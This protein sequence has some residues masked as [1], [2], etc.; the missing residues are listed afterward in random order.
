MPRTAMHFGGPLMATP[1]AKAHRTTSVVQ[2]L[3]ASMSKTKCA[4]AMVASEC[5]FAMVASE[6][7]FAVV[8]SECAFAMVA[9]ECAQAIA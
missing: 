1:H 4:F 3:S 8:A 5:A 2:R 7:A 9:S 6:C